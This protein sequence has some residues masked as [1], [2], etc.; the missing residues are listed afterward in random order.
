MNI[1]QSFDSPMISSGVQDTGNN[2]LTANTLQPFFPP[3]T[4]ETGMYLTQPPVSNSL[5][6][7]SNYTNTPQ[8]FFPSTFEQNDV[9]VNPANS[10]DHAHSHFAPPPTSDTMSP[11]QVFDGCV[12]ALAGKFTQDEVTGDWDEPHVTKWVELRGGEFSRHADSLQ[13]T[14]IL[15]TKRQFQATVG[16]RTDSPLSRAVRRPIVS[17]RVKKKI[18]GDIQQVKTLH[19]VL[20]EVSLK[21]SNVHSLGFDN[22]FFSGY[23]SA[24]LLQNEMLACGN[25]GYLT[26]CLL[27]PVA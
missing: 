25:D 6:F 19:I 10:N 2:I 4:E 5:F 12:V 8:S 15:T 18:A 23:R 24:G 11:K 26:F 22:P 9:N 21:I 16:K 1:F 27:F 20:P 17:G 3:S 13:V 14:H 7:H